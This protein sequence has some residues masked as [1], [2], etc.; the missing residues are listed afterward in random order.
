M[1]ILMKKFVV[2]LLSLMILASLLIPVLAYEETN[3]VA[4][5]GLGY[6]TQKV[7]INGISHDATFYLAGNV[8]TGGYSVFDTKARC[9][10][11]HQTV[12]VIFSTQGT[13][14]ETY[15]G[16]S[17]T[18]LGEYDSSLLRY[19]GHEKDSQSNFVKY[20]G[21]NTATG[22]KKIS[23]TG[24]LTTVNQDGTSQSYSFSASAG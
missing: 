10:R 17:K 2:I 14:Q 19:V 3:S 11:Y 12:T 7:K 16:G 13:G 6:D 23:A 15:S 5:V 4:R 24:R 1:K 21:T 20:G 22:I 9:V 18:S 8:T